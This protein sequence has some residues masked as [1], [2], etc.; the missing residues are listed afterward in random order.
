MRQQSHHHTCGAVALCNVVEALRLKPITEE[1]AAELCGSNAIYGTE[2]RDLLRACR[3]LRLIP[4][5]LKTRDSALAYWTVAG[6]LEH[7]NP[8]LILVD[9][10]DHWVALVGILGSRIVVADG[11]DPG[12]VTCW[13]AKELVDRWG[14]P[15]E[16]VIVGTRD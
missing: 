2:P 12:T 10:G 11:A 5:V 1:R 14:P 7:G 8:S 3:S 15:Y 9:D 6:A 13:T 4:T 16:A